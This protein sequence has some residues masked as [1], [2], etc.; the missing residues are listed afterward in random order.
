MEFATEVSQKDIKFSDPSRK[1]IC[2]LILL[3][4]QT[5]KMDFKFLDDLFLNQEDFATLEPL[6]GAA[7]GE[8]SDFDSFWNQKDYGDATTAQ[9]DQVDPSSYWNQFMA[10]HDLDP[11]LDE[12]GKIEQA[13]APAYAFNVPRLPTSE[14]EF[15][16]NL[17]QLPWNHEFHQDPSDSFFPACFATPMNGEPDIQL[18]DRTEISPAL[19]TPT[20]SS[21]SSDNGWRTLNHNENLVMA[22]NDAIP[23]VENIERN[24][25]NPVPLNQ[26]DHRWIATLN[27]NVN[28]SQKNQV[29]IIQDLRV[30][31]AA[32][33]SQ[34]TLPPAEHLMT[35]F[36]S[37]PPKW[38]VK[39]SK[40]AYNTEQ[41][42]KVSQ[43]RSKRA[44][45]HCQIRKTAVSL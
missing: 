3:L 45:W 27:T 40:K 41:R 30:G 23:A 21:A 42:K 19:L 17:A 14:V 44:C 24:L 8:V 12:S 18:C 15:T 2:I 37:Q 1:L 6:S 29:N 25:L 16:F 28:L 7:P 26:Q 11:L 13:A 20:T 36:E 5:R 4:C 22:C 43:V 33:G 38:S 39:R 34:G 31:P 9:A 35:A 32:F 10:G